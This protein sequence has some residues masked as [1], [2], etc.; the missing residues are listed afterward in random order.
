MTGGLIFVLIFYG[1]VY[2]VTLCSLFASISGLGIII[3][4]ARILDDDLVAQL[5][6]EKTISAPHKLFEVCHSNV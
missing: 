2:V 5:R 6:V 1:L 3:E 4:P